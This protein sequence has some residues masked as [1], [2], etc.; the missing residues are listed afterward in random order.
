[1]SSITEFKD[2]KGNSHHLRAFLKTIPKDQALDNCKMIIKNL[3]EEPESDIE[4]C[5]MGEMKEECKLNNEKTR[6]LK[7]FYKEKMKEKAVKAT[8][9]EALI[10]KKDVPND[11]NSEHKE[12]WNSYTY[13]NDGKNYYLGS[14][15]ELNLYGG[16]FAVLVSR[17]PFVLCGKS[18]PLLDGTVFYTIRYGGTQK[19]FQARETD[20]LQKNT[21]KGIL[22]SHSINVPDNKMLDRALEY[23]SCCISFYGDKLKE[24]HAVEYNGWSEDNTLFSLG[25]WG[26]TKDGINPIMTLVDT[27][28][29][30][31]FFNK[32]GTLEKWVAA[33]TPI[34]EYDV[35]RFLF[36]D[37]MTAPLKKLLQIESHTLVHHGTTSRGKTL[38]E[39]VISST[40]GNPKEME[41]LAGSSKVA[42]I[43]HVAGM[44]DIP[45]N[46]EEATES[47][48]REI[49]AQAVYDIANGKEKGRGQI[50]GKL[51][52]DI[53]TFR[54]TVH[55][56]CENELRENL[57]NAGAAY[58]TGQIGDLLP[59]GLGEIVTA[60]KRGVQENHGFFYPLYIQYIIEHMAELNGLYEDALTK[61][62]TTSD[63]SKG[64]Q[65]IAE[66]TKYLYG[67]IMVA[68]WLCERVFKEIGLPH[69]GDV[70][71]IVNRYF[72][73]CVLGEPVELD[74]IRALRLI[75]DW[76]ISEENKFD[77]V[78][79]R[80]DS[81]CVT[82]GLISPEYIDIIHTEFVKKM[83]ENGFNP[84]T[85]KKLLFQNRIS[86]CTDKRQ[87]GD[88]VITVNEKKSAGIR[89]KKKSMN[90]ALKLKEEYSESENVLDI[91]KELARITGGANLSVLKSI[92]G[93]DVEEYLSELKKEGKISQDGEIYR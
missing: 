70:K 54:T 72:K 1:M 71:E 25:K 35:S 9:D 18:K 56:T 88:Y 76:V 86:V 78:G 24:T 42:I 40:F 45:V 16:E 44:N 22:T 93:E 66:R 43:A 5:I 46:L 73:E 17:T 33:V 6:N 65:G 67:G 82:Y 55:V 90:E 79:Y 52:N 20:L 31:A 7:K 77:N 37:S 85:I 14:P 61:I 27:P 34:M 89:I 21:L 30:F 48:A 11:A 59:E 26:I 69:R 75:N 60:V 15:D 74:Y 58:R 39:N 41:F 91:V 63:L 57:N 28:Q 51:R 36:Y 81:N 32:K 68:G 64:S 10:S 80:K 23:I 38:Q 4:A 2:E 83:K 53:K 8:P 84:T 12:Y 47:K 49:I 62:D 92:F 13:P 3:M 87:I 19:E 50:S 29:H